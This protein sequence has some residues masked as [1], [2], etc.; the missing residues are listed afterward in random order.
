MADNKILQ[1]RI[2]LKIDTL[3][4]WSKIWETFIPLAGE[5]ILF[6]IPNGNPQTVEG[7]GITPPQ[8]ISKTGNGTTPLK[9]LPWDSALAADV[10]AWVK[11]GDKSYRNL[12][13]EFD[14]LLTDQHSLTINGFEYL[15]FGEKV[16]D[17]V[18]TIKGADGVTVTTTPEAESDEKVITIGIDLEK[19]KLANALHFIGVSETP[20]T[21][22]QKEQP[23][24]NEEQIVL[25][26]LKA[27]DVVLYNGNEFVWTADGTNGVWEELGEAS[28][29]ISDFNNYKTAEQEWKDTN[30][31]PFST[32]DNGYTNKGNDA[33][34]MLFGDNTWHGGISRA[35]EGHEEDAT[36][37]YIILD[38]G[39]STA[40]IIY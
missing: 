36:E 29:I 13:Q 19:L 1:T 15:P 12:P 39:S 6:Q 27:G 2:K 34:N 24:I 10:A 31:K 33:N 9:S 5:K 37:D 18:I 7:N 40:N 38:C 8:V 23:T 16:N 11:P 20:I 3:E 32:T 30:W 35:I 4:N 22:G 21:D 28:S 17:K 26:D 25:D 14:N